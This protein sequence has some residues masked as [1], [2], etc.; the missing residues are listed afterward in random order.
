MRG[1]YTWSIGGGKRVKVYTRPDV[2]SIKSTEITELTRLQ[3]KVTADL[4]ALRSFKVYEGGGVRVVGASEKR[5][6]LIFEE[7]VGATLADSRPLQQLLADLEKQ[8]K[9]LKFDW[10]VMSAG[11][12]VRGQEFL[13]RLKLGDID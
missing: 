9:P 7:G 1:D 3:Q 4:D 13:E 5:L 6:A 10:F 2:V 12:K 8:A 11:K